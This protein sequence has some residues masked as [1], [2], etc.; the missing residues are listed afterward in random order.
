MAGGS[1]PSHQRWDMSTPPMTMLRV[2]RGLE[3][4]RVEQHI[5]AQAQQGEASCQAID[6]SHQ[7]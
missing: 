7:Q 2:V 6:T 3:H 5:A 4:D 1:R